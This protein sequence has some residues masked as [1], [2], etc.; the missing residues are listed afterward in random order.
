MRSSNREG[1]GMTTSERA[2]MRKLELENYEL[3]ARVAKDAEVWRDQALEL[4]DLRARLALL[5]EII[6]EHRAQ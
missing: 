4:I 1:C 2:K 3:R 5:A 6:E